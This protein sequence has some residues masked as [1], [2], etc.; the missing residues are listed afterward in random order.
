MLNLDEQPR[1]LRDC[2]R[3]K[4]SMEYLRNSAALNRQEG[5][6]LD[7]SPEPDPYEYSSNS[8][9]LISGISFLWHST[10]APLFAKLRS[11]RRNRKY[12]EIVRIFPH[13]L[14]CTHCEHIIK[15]R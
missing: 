7:R 4:F 14:I 1:G 13:T 15:Q 3:C 2:P 6:V 9:F 5:Y 8:S 12:Q 11:D 10:V